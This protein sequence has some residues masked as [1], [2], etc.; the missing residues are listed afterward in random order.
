MSGLTFEFGREPVDPDI[1]VDGKTPESE[2]RLYGS[3]NP[4]LVARRRA[5][6][7]KLEMEALDYSLDSI[8][9]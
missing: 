3:E 2:H 9:I 6:E 1:I 8:E 5:Y 7:L 4:L